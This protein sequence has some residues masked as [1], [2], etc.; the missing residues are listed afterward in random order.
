KAGNEDNAPS[1]TVYYD[2]GENLEEAV[3]L[4]GAEA[5]YR[6]FVAAATID[7]QAMIRRGLTRME[8]TG[9]EKRPNPMTQ[10]ELQ[11]MVDEWKPGAA[12]PRKSKAE[13]AAEAFEALSEEEK[14]A[15]LKQLGLAA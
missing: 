8:G 2:F 11:A 7:I 9:T 4:F 5:V 1:A 3:E 15:L 12:K 13:K 14:Q 10:E 6:R